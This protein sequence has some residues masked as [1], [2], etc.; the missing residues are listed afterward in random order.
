LSAPFAYACNGVK[1][2]EGLPPLEST[3]PRKEMIMELTGAVER[4]AD[5][6]TDLENLAAIEF[7]R[8]AVI[9]AG[10]RAV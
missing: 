10:P 9:P 2:P 3:L 8:T 5:I 6:N 7:G 4:L 1:Y